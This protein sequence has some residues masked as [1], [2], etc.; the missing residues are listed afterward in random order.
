[1]LS[2]FRMTR[3]VQFYE[4][5]E[6]GVVHFS[7]FFRYIEEAEHAMWRAAGLS[8]AP[9]DREIAWPRVA[10]ACEFHK[11]LRFEDE[12]EVHVRIVEISAKTMT[13]ACA[14]TRGATRIATGSMTI[15][16]VARR[17]NEPMKSVEIPAD[18]AARFQVS[19]R[20]DA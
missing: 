9:R 1:M 3:R 17:P 6:A 10:A 20:A 15:A 11:P 19:D 12:F 7:N 2:E 14:I 4:T 8:I 13:Y 18:V 5:D 16:C